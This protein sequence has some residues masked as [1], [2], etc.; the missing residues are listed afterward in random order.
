[1]RAFLFGIAVGAIGMYLNLMGFG[2]IVEHFRGW[3]YRASA[4][5]AA[6]LQ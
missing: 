1:M 2:P 6:T 4:P 3:W 5:H